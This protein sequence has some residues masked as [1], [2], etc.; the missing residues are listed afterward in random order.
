[1]GASGR[2]W[3][4][5]D[6]PLPA[7]S[8]ETYPWWQAATQ[9]KLV[10]QRCGRCG[11]YRH[12][13]KPICP[14]CQSPEYGWNEVSGRGTVYTYT[15]VHQAFVPSLAEKLPYV[16]AAIELEE[17]DGVRVVSNV[18]DVEPADVRIGMPVEVAWEDMGPELALPRFRPA[19][20]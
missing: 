9:H 7:A 10:V 17:L 1:M 13:P 19:R 5:D 3:F 8:A 12:P 16:V 4:P 2:R 20:R 18:V 6:M 14:L 15:V 11:E